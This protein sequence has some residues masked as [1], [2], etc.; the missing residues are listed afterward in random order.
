MFINNKT[1]ILKPLANLQ[2]AIALL[3]TIGFMIAIGTII[4]Q[5]QTLAFYKESY[6]EINPMFGF[7]SWKVITL[8]NFDRVYTS[9]WFVFVLF[10]FGSS[11]LACTFTTQLPSVKT[12]KIWKFIRNGSQY[13]NLKVNENVK[14]GISNAIAFNCNENKYHFFRQHKKGYAYSGLL[15]RVAPLV[16]HASIIVLLLGSTLGSF[17]GYTA[18]EIVPRGEISHI[19]NITK[20]GNTSYIPQTLFYRINNFWITYTKEQ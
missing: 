1:K 17:G 20:F 9:W 6:P 7:L 16:V 10:L 14:L 11:L 2:F 15:G 5:D 13:K 8:L 18:Q 4:E 12:F 19:Q 3:I